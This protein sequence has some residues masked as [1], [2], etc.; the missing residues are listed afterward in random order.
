MAVT[1]ARN[2][3]CE[4]FFSLP[5]S[6]GPDLREFR[7]YPCDTVL[8]AAMVLGARGDNEVNQAIREIRDIGKTGKEIVKTKEM[9]ALALPPRWAHAK[10]VMTEMNNMEV[11]NM[12]DGDGRW[13]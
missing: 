5:L 9:A 6:K 3:P 10:M 8:A 11:K 7:I 2:T 12:D 4:R 1:N 13:L